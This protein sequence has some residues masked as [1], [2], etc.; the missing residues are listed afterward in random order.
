MKSTRKN[1]AATNLFAVVR[2]GL[3]DGAQRLEADG[4]V[5]QVSSEEKEVEV[6]QQREEEVPQ[7][8]QER[9]HTKHSLQINN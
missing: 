5:Q 8:V 7:N 9:L 2:D 1:N 6:A 3:E 4:H